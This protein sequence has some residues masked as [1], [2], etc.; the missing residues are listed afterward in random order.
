[1]KSQS[2]EEINHFRETRAK[3]ANEQYGDPSSKLNCFGVTG[4]NGKTSVAWI[5]SQLLQHLGHESAYIG[6]LNSDLTTP[7]S[8]TFFGK[9]RALVDQ[10]VTS[11]VAEVSSHSLTQHRTR[12]C[13][14]D[15][16]VFTNL[17]RDHLDY[18]LDMESYFQAK[19]LLFSRDLKESNKKNRSIVLNI[20][21]SAGERI[22]HEL[23][24]QFPILTFSAKPKQLADLM[25]LE[26]NSTIENSELNF[27]YE[28]KKYACKTNL[29]GDYNG[30]NLL[31]GIASLLA[32]G[33]KLEEIIK[34]VP[35]V[36]CVPGRLERVKDSF[37]Q[38][39]FF[40]DYAH[41]P[42]A[43]IKAQ[44]SLKHIAHDAKL[45]TVFGCG[46]DRDRGKRPEMGRAVSSISE[47]S[48]ITSD[49][50]RSEDPLKI[51]ADIEPGMIPE[52]K[53]YIEPD[54]KKAIELAHSLATSKDLILVA[55]KGHE[56]YQ[57]IMGV[58]YPFSDQE[59]CAATG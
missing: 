54:R 13:N 37:Q 57:E 7:D 40:V 43:L 55:G 32:F 41:T 38:K 26:M 52:S 46:G 42:D 35:A 23:K 12:G 15:V 19:K 8:I 29:I 4:T 36:E 14:W 33:I 18:H 59:V 22:Y 53:F 44:Q 50:P 58:R 47:I 24:D 51:I 56:K 10:D 2:L 39:T 20:A 34:A 49:N 21:D 48:I 11:L 1:M 16:A 28:A 31:A 5:I 45:I 17:T 30:E 3:S 27:S 6:T 25:L 9:L